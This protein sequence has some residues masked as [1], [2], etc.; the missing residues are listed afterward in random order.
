MTL[1]GD[2]EVQRTT[3]SL[4]KAKSGDYP[5]RSHMIPTSGTHVL[6]HQHLLVLENLDSIQF[7]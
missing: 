3:L 5:E 1:C 6:G 7:G 2:K 4:V